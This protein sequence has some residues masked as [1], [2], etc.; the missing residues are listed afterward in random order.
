MGYTLLIW[1][2]RAIKYVNIMPSLGPHIAAIYKM[3]CTLFYNRLSVRV[4]QFQLI[5]LLFFVCLIAIVMSGYGTS[6]RAIAYYGNI[7]FTAHGI[8]HDM[9][10]PVY[11]LMYS[12]VDKEVKYLDGTYNIPIF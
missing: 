1:W 4:N 10:Y 7:T 12:Q 8:F 5:D 9:I 3:V 11:Y 6:S 2:L